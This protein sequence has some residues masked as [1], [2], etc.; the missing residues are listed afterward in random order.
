MNVARREVFYREILDG[1]RR[2][3]K[4]VVVITHDDRYFDCADRIVKLDVG[5]V[6][7]PVDAREN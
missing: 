2:R 6:V 5:R 7:T 3:G 4:T 1:L